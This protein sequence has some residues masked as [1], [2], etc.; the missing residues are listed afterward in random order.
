MN[1]RKSKKIR[2]AMNV[3]SGQFKSEILSAAEKKV[4]MLNRYGKPQH[5]VL[6]PKRQIKNAI[7]RLVPGLA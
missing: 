6:S 7:P 4:G 1:G 3:L 2:H 5:R